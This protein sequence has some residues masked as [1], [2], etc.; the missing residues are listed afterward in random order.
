MAMLQNNF[1]AENFS[2][3]RRQYN[4]NLVNLANIQTDFIVDLPKTLNKISEYTD[5]ISNLTIIA[6]NCYLSK[7][8]KDFKELENKNIIFNKDFNTVKLEPELSYVIEP[9]EYKNKIIS[10]QKHRIYDNDKKE[11]RNIDDL[12]IRKEPINIVTEENRYEYILSLNF[13][14]LKTFNN[15]NLKLGSETLSYP[16][17]SKVYYI[18][19]TNQQKMLKLINLNAFNMDLDLYKNSDNNYELDLERL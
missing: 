11:L 2:E 16:T 3:F 5:K 12:L 7:I 4:L 10:N 1:T 17:I 9:V 8:G 6:G 15:I 14:E 19:N 13:N 18:D